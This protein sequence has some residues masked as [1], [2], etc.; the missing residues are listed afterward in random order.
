MSGNYRERNASISAANFAFV[1]N[2]PTL[3]SNASDF[4]DAESDAS[5]LSESTLST[6]LDRKAARDGQQTL[7]DTISAERITLDPWSESLTENFDVEGYLAKFSSIPIQGPTQIF[8]HPSVRAIIFGKKDASGR[9]APIPLLRC[10]Q[11]EGTL[12]LDSPNESLF[13]GVVL[14]QFVFKVTVSNPHL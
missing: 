12:S 14:K 1:E 2:S 10:L 7:A 9:I 4:S 6:Y 13:E 8:G 11:F 3:H 5:T